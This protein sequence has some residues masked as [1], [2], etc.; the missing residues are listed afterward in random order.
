MPGS[1]QVPKEV[2][3]VGAESAAFIEPVA[4]RKDGIKAMFAKQRSQQERNKECM[5][6]KRSVSPVPFSA[7][8]ET[9]G[10]EDE[11]EGKKLKL[12]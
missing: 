6:R 7:R 5:K 9:D 12:V 2:G 4:T 8:L 1:Y 10:K 3:K 11:T